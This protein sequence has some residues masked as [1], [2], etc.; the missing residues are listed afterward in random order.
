MGNESHLSEDDLEGI[1]LKNRAI[2]LGMVSE[3]DG[4]GNG[5]GWDVWRT[6]LTPDQISNTIQ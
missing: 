3:W 1:G 6:C 2:A 5:N 4:Y